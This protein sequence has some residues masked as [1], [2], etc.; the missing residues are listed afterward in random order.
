MDG[1]AERREMD[2]SRRLRW[3]GTKSD[4]STSVASRSVEEDESTPAIGGAPCCWRYSAILLMQVGRRAWVG[5]LGGGEEQGES[6]VSAC[7]GSGG[8]GVAK[9]AR[10]RSTTRLEKDSRGTS[11]RRT[12]ARTS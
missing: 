7:L 8:V 3:D 5:E 2:E 12:R 10:R 6:G 1:C 9:I 4:E 11:S